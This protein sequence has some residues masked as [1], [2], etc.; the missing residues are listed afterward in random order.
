L[1]RRRN[2]R[3]ESTRRSEGIA[4]LAEAKGLTDEARALYQ[5]AAERWADYGFVLEEGQAHLGLARCLIALGDEQAAIG[6]SRKRAPSS[7]D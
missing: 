3:L 6:R 7:L 2:S 1:L 4:I 5:Q